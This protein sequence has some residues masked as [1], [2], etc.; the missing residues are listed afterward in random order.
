MSSPDR[1]AREDGDR[2]ADHARAACR[3]ILVGVAAEAQRP[4]RAKKECDREG[5]QVIEGEIGIITLLRSRNAS[6]RKR[7]NGAASGPGSGG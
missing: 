5:D 7:A 2:N 3:R 1:T 6:A 4:E